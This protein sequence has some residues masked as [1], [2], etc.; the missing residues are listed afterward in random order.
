M[1]KV[2]SLMNPK[3]GAGKT[4]TTVNLAATFAQEQKVAVADCD[5]Q[6]SV[7][8]W[9]GNKKPAFTVQ[10]AAVRQVAALPKNPRAAQFGYIIIDTPAGMSAAEATMVAQ[11]SDLVIVPA[12][13]SL[14]DIEPAIA[15]TKTLAK[16]GT[17]Y[18]LL[19]TQVPPGNRN[20]V[21]IIKRMLHQRNLPF[22]KTTIR[23][24]EAHV[25]AALNHR[26]IYDTGSQAR[27]AR[28]DFDTL[29]DEI[30]KLMTP[31]VVK[32]L[33]THA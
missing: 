17:P 6:R 18:R 28:W 33:V 3:G 13:C 16:S 14:L 12:K 23:L 8:S 31:E 15:L 19:L 9:F 11:L 10:A 2:I 24:L 4:T 27:A 20:S 32:T 25:Q 21:N 26:T 29:H 22:F 5:P 7:L 30:L 1:P